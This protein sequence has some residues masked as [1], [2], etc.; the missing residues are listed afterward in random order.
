MKRRKT[1]FQQFMVALQAATKSK[2]TPTDNEIITKFC[3]H[4]GILNPVTF[5]SS[6]QQFILD[7][8]SEGGVVEEDL[9]EGEKG[10]RD[11][12]MGCFC[13]D[14]IGVEKDKVRAVKYLQRA[15]DAGLPAAINYLGFCLERGFGIEADSK[16]AAALYQQAAETGW[17]DAIHNLG[18]LYIAGSG[19]EKDIKKGEE[20]ILKVAEQ[21]DAVANHTLG[22]FYQADT[23]GPP[24]LSKAIHHFEVAA[25]L[26]HVA[27]LT[28]LGEIYAA[29][30]GGKDR[31]DVKADEY[32]R[33]AAE[34]GSVVAQLT[35]GYWEME[36]KV[37]PPDMR[38]AFHWFSVAA[39]T[40][41]PEGQALLGE[42]YLDGHGVD[43]PD[44][45]KGME[46]IQLA[47]AQNDGPTLYELFLFFHARG[48]AED[49]ARA[50]RFLQAAVDLKIPD[51]EFML[52]ML[53]LHGTASGV[54]QNTRKA[55]ELWMKAAGRG[56]SEAQ[57]EVGEM[58]EIGSSDI[59]FDAAKAI[60]YYIKAAEN[61]NDTAKNRLSMIYVS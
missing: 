51:A 22:E 18:I 53:H 6:F 29:G 45:I 44:Q 24:N 41:D 14:G 42:M 30:E 26:G 50:L 3:T 36:G 9:K 28:E 2:L 33:Q 57:Y 21:G 12:V 34:K 55:I 32:F 15:S 61:G 59:P 5:D 39:D 58:Y 43:R 7:C 35:L 40:G 46:L 38:K 25:Q 20:L 48:G 52:G 10:T 11:F 49:D 23:L 1:D 31:D 19:V 4:R 8:E 27:A 37:R 54:E 17:L 13:A 60:Q 47:A 16:K 56:H